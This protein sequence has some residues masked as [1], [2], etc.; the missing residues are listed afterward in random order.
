MI[1]NY[2]IM[3]CTNIDCMFLDHS[4]L[5]TCNTGNNCKNGKTAI[6]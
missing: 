2:A 3:L 4:T 5:Q 1:S 6:V